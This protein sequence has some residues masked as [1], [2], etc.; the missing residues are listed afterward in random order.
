MDDIIVP[1]QVNK[2]NS[3]NT[4]N[5]KFETVLK[6]KIIGFS[7]KMGSGK[8]YI[9]EKIIGK[10]LYDMGYKVHILAF[11]DQL[12]YEVGIRKYIL[13][14][15]KKENDKK[16]YEKIIYKRGFV[17]LIKNLFFNKNCLI[18]G[19]KDIFNYFGLLRKYI[20][21]KIIYFNPFI[22]NTNFS[23][24]IGLRYNWFKKY[25]S[26][27]LEH[28]NYYNNKTQ[29]NIQNLQNNYNLVF[30][31]KPTYIRKILQKKG[32]K[33]DKDDYIWI[34][35]LYFRIMNI[36]EKSYD[37]EKDVFIITDVRYLNEMSFI[38]L[39]RGI[40]VRIKP[41]LS[42]KNEEDN[43]VNKHISEIELDNIKDN[44]YDC[45]IENTFDKNLNADNIM[46][47]IFK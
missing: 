25:S 21:N 43:S 9:G 40:I 20:F 26:N 10:K 13:E 12:K 11:A 37:K 34:N 15:K 44:I 22:I 14:Q 33:R 7:G 1:E 24:S 46:N 17:N 35:S 28:Y 6:S 5:V 4:K 36:L 39:M 45:I 2:Y 16:E 38:K 18:N 29:E 31:D 19:I 42:F 32:D 27:S 47:I 23:F 41:V 8:N 30:N 3:E